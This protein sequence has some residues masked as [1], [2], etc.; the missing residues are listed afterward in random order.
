MDL[1]N[2]IN[3]HRDPEMEIVMETYWKEYT[4]VY[5]VLHQFTLCGEYSR[6]GQWGAA[7]F[8][9]DRQDQPKWIG[10]TKMGA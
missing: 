8:L 9:H 2:R 5:D 7:D 6:Y 1:A 3:A 4:Q 10:L